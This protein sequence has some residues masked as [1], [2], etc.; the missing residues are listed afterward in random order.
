MPLLRNILVLSLAFP[1]ALSAQRSANLATAGVYRHGVIS[2]SSQAASLVRQIADTLPAR[3]LRASPADSLRS[4]KIGRYTLRG[5]G[6]G[7]AIGIVGGLIGSRYIHCGC[8]DTK[9]AL[10]S[11]FWFG[12][13]GASAGGIVGA[14]VGGIADLRA[15]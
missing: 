13:I 1:A 7:A 10:G 4:R 9:K 11:A 3:A 2:I 6:T 14:L 15:R 5:L 8:S 12:G